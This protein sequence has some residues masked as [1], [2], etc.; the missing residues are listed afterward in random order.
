MVPV[1]VNN[2]LASLCLVTTLPAV[3][4]TPRITLADDISLLSI[5]MTGVAAV[6]RTR[7]VVVERV[8]EASWVR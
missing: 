4:N 2:S 6:C 5:A 7:W 1:T 3:L 8:A